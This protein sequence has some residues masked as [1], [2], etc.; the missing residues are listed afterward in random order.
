MACKGICN[1]Y[2]AKKPSNGAG[3]YTQNKRCMHCE[4]FIVGR[5]KRI[6]P[7][8]GYRLRGTPKNKKYKA[9]LK[10]QTT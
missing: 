4:I 5:D 7:C 3:W 1:R 9:K 10:A 2:K 6:C 8:C